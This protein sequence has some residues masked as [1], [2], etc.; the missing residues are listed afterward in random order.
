M[1][2]QKLAK[3]LESSIQFDLLRRRNAR[4]RH[5]PIGNEMSLEKSFGE[6]KRLRTC[7]KQFLCLLNLLLSLRV[8]LIHS[9]CLS[10]NERR[11]VATRARVSNQTP[12]AMHRTFK[13]L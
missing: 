13:S 6:T 11:I 4:I 3:I 1:L 7:K 9:I 2:I 5:Y 10:K 8:E 12:D